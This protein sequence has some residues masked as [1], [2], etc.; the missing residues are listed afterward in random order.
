MKSS[1]FAHLE[2]T[3]LGR[4]A[5]TYVATTSSVRKLWKSAAD[6]MTSRKPIARTCNRSAYHS[7]DTRLLAHTNESAMMVFNPA[8]AILTMDQCCRKGDASRSGG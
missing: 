1:G 5:T 7:L 8:A 6:N 3:K 2:Q 4:G